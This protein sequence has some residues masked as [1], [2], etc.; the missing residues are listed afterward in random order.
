ML[1]RSFYKA[2][3]GPSDL[4]FPCKSIWNLKAP[5]RVALY[6]WTV[7]WGRILVII[8]LRGVIRWSG[9]VVC[10]VVVG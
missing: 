10:A 6:I 4:L 7:A 2:L 1:F 9:G 3:V 5:R 8:S